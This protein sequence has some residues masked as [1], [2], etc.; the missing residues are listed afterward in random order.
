M[1]ALKHG[2][3]HHARELQISRNRNVGHSR[4]RAE[5]KRALG[6]ISASISRPRSDVRVTGRSGY[7]DSISAAIGPESSGTCRAT[8]D[9][10]RTRY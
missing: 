9:Y 6:R 2:L 4:R 10:D 3:L 1:H 7:R 5:D 8:S